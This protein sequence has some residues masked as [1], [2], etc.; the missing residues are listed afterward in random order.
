MPTQRSIKAL[1]DPLNRAFSLPRL[2]RECYQA[3]AAV[4]WTLTIFDRTKGWL[5]PHLH[6]WFRELMMH[7]AARE[8]LLC[9]IYGLMRPPLYENKRPS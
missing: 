9:P 8:G 4:F 2:H 3:G 7:A 6:Q 5:T 1:R